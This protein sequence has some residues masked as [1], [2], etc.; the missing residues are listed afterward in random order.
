MSQS[1]AITATAGIA[2]L[3]TSWR[4]VQVKGAGL[5][6]C[7][8]VA[9]AATL[10][11]ASAGLQARGISVLTL[12]IA[13]GMVVGNTAYPHIP[14]MAAHCG[15]GVETAKQTLL[16][17]G[18]ILYGLRLTLQDVGT[19]G[20]AGAL[21]DV[22]IVTSTFF[23]V[24]IAGTRWLGMDRRSAMLIAAGS[25]ICGAAAILATEPVIRARVE[26]VAVAVASV[27]VF[28]T[29]AVFV[30]P[31][32]FRWNAQWHFLAGGDGAFGAYIGSTVHEVAQ[33][34]AAAGAI[35]P[36]VA[37]TA[38]IAKMVRVLLLAPFLMGLS[39]WLARGETRGRG[40]QEGATQARPARLAFPWFALGFVAVV[41]VN[42]L[43]MLDPTVRAWALT[44]D[45]VVL[46]MAMAA[47]GVSTHVGAM[48]RAGARP[49]LLGLLAFV[50]LVLAGAAIN[51]W[52]PELVARV[53]A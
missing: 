30:Y 10:L 3:R 13:L 33:V 39:V 35:G 43:R 48:R 45:N 32:L 38:V 42:S 11:G 52:V 36:H 8:A 53:W 21:V 5:L 37:D 7:G 49:L 50:W 46:A 1:P 2:V 44:I 6:L 31:L 25:S 16:R 23:F 14:G 51:R 18:V 19:F 4:S 29:V 22:A 17:T 40:R 15:A 27:V 41:T 12:A 34:V 28:G 20:V 9:L 47:L 26:Q 24:T